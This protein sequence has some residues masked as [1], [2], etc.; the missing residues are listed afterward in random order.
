M[1]PRFYS[2]V[3]I[4]LS[5]L[6]LMPFFG[7]IL[8]AYNLKEIGKQQLRLFFIVAGILWSVLSR[9]FVGEIFENALIELLVSNFVGAVILSFSWDKFFSGYTSF[10]TKKVWKPV[11]IFIG[12]C[13]V[14]LLIQLFA[15]PV[16]K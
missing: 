13:L 2:K 16:K 5:T 9:K 3:A 10:E 12:I 15:F 14:S 11:L 4:G 1:K 6:F 8:F 7:C